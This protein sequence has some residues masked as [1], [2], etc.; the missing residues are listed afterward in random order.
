MDAR[1][2][3]ITMTFVKGFRLTERTEVE[4]GPRGVAGNRRFYLVDDEGNMINGKRLGRLLELESDYDPAA[5]RLALRFPDGTRVEDAVVSGEPIETL[6]YGRPVRSTLV[7]GPFSAAMSDWAGRSIRLA[8]TLEPGAGIDRGATAAATLLGTGSL[9]ELARAAGVDDVDGRRFRMLF[10]VEGP[11]AHAEDGWIGSRVAIGRAVVVPRG[12]VGR[13][14]VTTLDPD[15]GRRDLDTLGAI[16]AYRRDVP[17]TE[18]LPF[19]IWAEVV[20]P[21]LVR[22]GD[23]VRAGL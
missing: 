14:A 16:A 9:A 15:R 2:A 21:G 17:T 20:E 12:N 10:G 4:L 11:D 1:V 5:E 22:V 3:W 23:P 6:F 13:C 19:G 8:K 7:E 18:P